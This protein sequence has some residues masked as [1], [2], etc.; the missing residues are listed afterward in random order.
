MDIFSK[1]RRSVIYISL[2][3]IAIC[4]DLSF[5]TVVKYKDGANENT[6]HKKEFFER[7]LKVI[8][9]S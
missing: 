1:Y 4:Q 2:K 9:I 5:S 6:V 7:N 8:R 3:E